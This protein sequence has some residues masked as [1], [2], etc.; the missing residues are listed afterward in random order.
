MHTEAV[1][2]SIC[3][4]H[5]LAEFCCVYLYIASRVPLM[6][7]F[8]YYA[9]NFDTLIYVLVIIVCFLSV[10]CSCMYV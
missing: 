1:I 3:P 6:H 8:A 5:F 2:I 7:C 9:G 10:F 4:A